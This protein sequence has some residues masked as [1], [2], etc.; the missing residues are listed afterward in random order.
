MTWKAKNYQ[1][2]QGEKK[3]IQKHEDSVSSLL[4]NFKHS[5]IHI[6]GVPAKEEREKE[7]GN[8]FEKIMRE[9]FPIW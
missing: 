8:L 4:Y 1:S 7:I 3:R 6:T 9:N 5:N 2:E